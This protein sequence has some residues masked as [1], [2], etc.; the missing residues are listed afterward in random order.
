MDPLVDPID[1]G[2][3]PGQA[4]QLPHAQGDQAREQ[5]KAQQPHRAHQERSVAW[6]CFGRSGRLGAHGQGR[7]RISWLEGGIMLWFRWNMTHKEPARV[8][9]TRVLVKIRASIDQPPSERVFMC[10]K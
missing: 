2:F 3:L 4:L 5:K 8:I 9:T 10:R 7:L 1:Q 6:A